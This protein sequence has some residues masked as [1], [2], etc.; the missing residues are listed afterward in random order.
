MR[1]ALLE[2][3]RATGDLASLLDRNKLEE[4]ILSWSGNDPLPPEINEL[5]VRYR[6][7]VEPFS[8]RQA[9]YSMQL[10]LLYGAF[11]RLIEGLLIGLADALSNV[12]P[13]FDQ[14]PARVRENHRRKSL[15]ALRDE[16]W[17]SRQADP[18]L[19]SRLIENLNSCESRLSNYALNS[20]A[21][22][23]HGANFRRAQIDEAFR[24]LDVSN[25]CVRAASTHHFRAYLDEEVR[26]AGLLDASLGAIDDLAERRNEIAHGSPSQLLNVDELKGYLDFVRA[27]GRGAYT[28]LCQ[29]VAQF[30]VGHHAQALGAIG[31]IHYLHVVCLDT[32]VLPEGTR[33]EVG[34]LIA[35]RNEG[36]SGF[37]LGEIRR[38]R[39]ES[40]DVPSFRTQ[41]GL[42]V[43]I[44]TSIRLR[45]TRDLYLVARDN[46]TAIALARPL[47]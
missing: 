26:S 31:K 25:L 33:M 43:C 22:A 28:V 7:C 9:Q 23:R 14:L 46:Q 24:E 15:D 18:A 10:V 41:R 35:M 29:Y 1:S 37:T 32:G 30:V 21:Y 13:S 47:P 17:L 36:N 40:G 2:F 44:E 38:L 12:V 8:L 5:L 42:E 34:D 45:E 19:A 4:Q 6:R 16:V 20:P 27:L 3:E 11:E 39:L